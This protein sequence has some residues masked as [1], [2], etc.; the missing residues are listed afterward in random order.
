[1]LIS[2][3]Q[4]EVA[5]WSAKNFPNDTAHSKFLGMIEESGELC[6]ARIDR[7]EDEDLDEEPNHQ[8]CDAISD[9]FIYLCDYCNKLDIS[10]EDCFTQSLSLCRIDDFVAMQEETGA[11]ICSRICSCLGRIAHS[12]LK[13][14][15]GIRGSQ[16][17]HDNQHRLEISSLVLLMF[18]YINRS[19][20]MSASCVIGD[21]WDK[22]KQRDW[23]KNRQDGTT[24]PVSSAT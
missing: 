6:D 13:A 18:R 16:E 12:R 10:I 8:E 11:M 19:T 20:N 1:M 9:L 21:T 17:F 24:L 15:Q 14:R 4:R 2:E 5:E 22:V 23:T 7:Y 3:M